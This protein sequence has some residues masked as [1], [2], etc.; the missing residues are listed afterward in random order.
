M[1]D[2]DSILSGIKILV[3]DDEPD[4][5]TVTTLILMQHHAEVIAAPT[6]HE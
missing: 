1:H 6:A 3:V 5:L 2:K 4:V